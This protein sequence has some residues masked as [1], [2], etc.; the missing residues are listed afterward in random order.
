MYCVVYMQNTTRKK[1]CPTCDHVVG[2]ACKLCPHCNTKIECGRKKPRVSSTSLTNPSNQWDLLKKR[3]LYYDYN[4]AIV[5][6]TGLHYWDACLYNECMLLHCVIVY[7]F[8]TSDD[9][10]PKNCGYR[11]RKCLI[12]CR[13]YLA[14][15]SHK[16]WS[17]IS[18]D[19]I[20]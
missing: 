1:K 15:K 10:S 12:G 5:L 13:E 11:C 6:Q 18:A 19:A 7:I 9:S 8:L 14:H 16:N 20:A 2:N 17:P 4:Y 3:V